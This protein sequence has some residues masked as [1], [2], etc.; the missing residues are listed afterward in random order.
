MVLEKKEKKLMDVVYEA[1]S[2]TP[3]GQLLI[4]PRDLLEKVT[5]RIEFSESDLET[6]LNRLVLD[7]YCS[8]E[9]VRTT[10]GETMYLIS[11]RSAGLSYFRDKQIA[12]RKMITKIIITLLIAALSVSAKNIIQLI[13]FS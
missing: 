4:S 10:G 6:N 9:K 2:G 8:Y 1:V 7:N 13:F 12:R 5:Y 3:K 11:L